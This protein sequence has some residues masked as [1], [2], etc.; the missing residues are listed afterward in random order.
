MGKTKKQKLKVKNK[1]L[2]NALIP[3]SNSN[4]KCCPVIQCSQMLISLIPAELQNIKN[5]VYPNHPQ[6]N[7]LRLLYN[8]MWNYFPKAIFYPKTPDDVAFLI[9]QLFRHKQDVGIR[10]GGHSYEPTSITSEFLIDVSSMNQTI[11]IAKD[12]KT[13]TFSSGFR[14]GKLAT[15]LKKKNLILSTG[16]C[17]C[18]GVSGITLSGGKTP[19]GRLYGNM[20][21]NM[22]QAKI[23]NYKGEILTANASENSDLWWA[24]KGAGTC[25]FGVVTEFTANVYNDIYFHQNVYIWQWNKIEALKILQTYQHWFIAIKSNNITSSFKIQYSNGIIMMKLLVTKYSKMPLK[26]DEIFATLYNP[27]IKHI[28]GYYCDKIETFVHW[29]GATYYPF[30]KI[31]TNMLYKPINNDGLSLIID[32]FEKQLK[33]NNEGAFGMEYT[34]LGGVIKDGHGCYW[35]RDAISVLDYTYEWRDQLHSVKLI[36][37]VNDLYLKL[38]KYTSKYSFYTLIDYAIP[39]Y[40]TTYFGKNKDKLIEIKAKYDPHNYFTFELGIPNK[41]TPPIPIVYNLNDFKNLGWM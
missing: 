6:Y 12:K 27:S 7:N 25:N 19:L 29:C 14:L 31:K 36:K 4:L 13:A 30:T 1:S 28:E 15:E 22:V 41:N 5:A 26:E 40:M 34:Q 24:L 16:E 11:K 33:L 32:T 18:V 8:K 35:P 21:D 39:D 17:A 38:R 10:C 3:I 23:V 2:K 37:I 20:S 9:K